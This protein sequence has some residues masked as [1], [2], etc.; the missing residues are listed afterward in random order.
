[1]MITSERQPDIHCVLSARYSLLMA[2]ECSLFLCR[3]RQTVTQRTRAVRHQDK[4]R[5]NAHTMGVS[6]LDVV[7][8][9]SG[10]VAWHT[11]TRLDFTRN[12]GSRLSPSLCRT[13]S[14]VH[15]SSSV[16]VAAKAS[17]RMAPRLILPLFEI[18]CGVG[19]IDVAKLGVRLSSSCPVFVCFALVSASGLRITRR[20]P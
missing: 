5:M 9:A 12:F 16:G 4:P 18:F 11:E 14:F 15:T 20:P 19:T 6:T 17:C 10:G 1:M 7:S 13:A 8:S 3:F 2:A